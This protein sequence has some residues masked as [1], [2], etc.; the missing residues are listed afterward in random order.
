MTS[1]SPS[2][3]SPWMVQLRTHPL[4]CACMQCMPE[5][6]KP[7]EPSPADATGAVDAANKSPD[8]GAAAGAHANAATA[9]AAPRDA[10][11]ASTPE[12]ASPVY[13]NPSVTPDP[14]GTAPPA[15]SHLS[16]RA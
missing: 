10:S 3:N 14:H 2:S 16:V 1:I 5:L 9:A 8:A 15:G 12:P 4:G 6:M 7:A 11:N 13:A